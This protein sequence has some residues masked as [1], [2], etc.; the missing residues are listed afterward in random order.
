MLKFLKKTFNTTYTENGAPTLASTDSHCLDLFSTIGAL[1]N[2]PEDD[3]LKL[4]NR[5]WI[6][7]PDLTIKILFFAR[8][9]RGGLGERRIFRIILQNLAFTNDTSIIKNLHHIAEYGRYDDLFVLENTP[10]EE[11]MYDFIRE[12]ILLDKK[13]MEN[14]GEEISLLGK[15]M[16]SINASSQKTIFLAKKM[17]KKLNMKN[18]EYRKLLS[19]L[20]S[21]IKILENN[22]RLKDY[23]F[24]YSKQP[25]KAMMKYRQAFFRNDSDRYTKFMERVREGKEKL[26]TGTLYP[27]EIITP[28]LQFK[29]QFTKEERLG[30]DATWN[31][32]PDY[33]NDENALVVVD[34]SGSMYGCGN[35]LPAAVAMSL[36]L[37]F[38]QRNKGHF[39]NHFITFSERPRLIEVKG[40]N[41]FEQISYCMS[42]NEVANTNVAAVFELIL[43]TAIKNKVPQEDLPKTLF[44]ISDMEFDSCAVN[45][46]ISNFDHAKKIFS[47]AGYN[48]PQIVFW[49]VS[50]RNH[51]QPVSMNEQG[52][53]LVSG[54]TPRLFQMVMSGDMSPYDNMIEILSNERYANLQ[55]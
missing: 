14:G 31:A 35:P 26:N 17:A 29:R 37:Y 55:A 54:C 27:Y 8:D 33:T 34:G 6:E 47:K 28:C 9:I 43:K 22:L 19:N 3:V 13:V 45:S 30:L 10:C 39:A 50:S 23:T 1:R 20:R 38:A 7:D 11:K 52:V 48:L 16:P 53:A 18:N 32:L 44:F 36:G 4:F 41:I 25:S 15:W 40:S 2:T 12:Q 5:A 49:N 21:K 24:D 42:F 46:D 51:H